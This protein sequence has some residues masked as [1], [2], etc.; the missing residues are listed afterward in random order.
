MS[1]YVVNA[2]T[3][4]EPEPAMLRLLCNGD[5]SAN[6]TRAGLDIRPYFDAVPD[7]PVTLCLIHGHYEA[8]LY[9]PTRRER[10]RGWWYVHR[11][12]LLRGLLLT[13]SVLAVV[14]ALNLLLA[15]ANDLADWISGVWR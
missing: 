3:G 13:L 6:L 12:P 10:L 8:S 15:G 11:W 4:K 2:R 14:V 7:H 9:R 1:L 5:V